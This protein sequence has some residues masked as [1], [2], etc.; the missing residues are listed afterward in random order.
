MASI[1]KIFNE[2]IRRLAKKEIKAATEPLRTQIVTL[3]KKVGEQNALIKQLSKPE[4]AAAQ[5]AASAVS[6]EESGEEGKKTRMPSARIRKIRQQLR[7]TQMQL[8]QLLE[9]SHSAVVKWEIDKA[10][11]RSETKAKIAAL[12]KIGKREL[13]KRLDDLSGNSEPKE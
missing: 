2:E 1:Q 13:K 10:S 12:G 3:R 6:E 9:V 5:A 7:L 8:A 4:K 11:P